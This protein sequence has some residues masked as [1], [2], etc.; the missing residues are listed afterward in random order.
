MFYDILINRL[1]YS[2]GGVFMALEEKR[3]NVKYQGR[4]DYEVVYYD[5]PDTGKKYF[6][7][8]GGKERLKNEEIRTYRKEAGTFAF[9][10][11]S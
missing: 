4:D 7:L 10:P 5:V 1:K 2:I 9:S 11:S 3:N 8:D 6:F